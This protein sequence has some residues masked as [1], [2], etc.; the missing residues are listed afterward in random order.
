[1]VKSLLLKKPQRIEALGLVFLLALL[2]W[3]LMERSLRH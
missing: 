1:M 3:R 2:R